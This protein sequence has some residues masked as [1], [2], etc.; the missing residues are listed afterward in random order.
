MKNGLDRIVSLG[1]L[2]YSDLTSED[3]DELENKITA[4]LGAIDYKTAMQDHR[5]HKVYYKQLDPKPDPGIRSLGLEILLNKAEPDKFVSPLSCVMTG[6]GKL[7]GY[8]M[9]YIPGRTYT[10]AIKALKEEGTAYIDTAVGYLRLVK[11]GLS[12]LHRKGLYHGDV[13]GKN[14]VITPSNDIKLIDPWYKDDRSRGCQYDMILVHEMYREL[15][16]EQK[17]EH[18]EKLGDDLN[19]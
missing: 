18:N 11:N 17:K 1:R 8:T 10:E 19:F 14:I 9:E 7:T 2:K 12:S 3:T 13:W 4:L 16:K 6:D 15:L 5:K